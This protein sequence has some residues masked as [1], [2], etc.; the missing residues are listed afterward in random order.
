MEE[1]DQSSSLSPLFADIL[2]FVSTAMLSCDATF[3]NA[4]RLRVIRKDKLLAWIY[5]ERPKLQNVL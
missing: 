2:A 1:A 3:D 5:E 4:K